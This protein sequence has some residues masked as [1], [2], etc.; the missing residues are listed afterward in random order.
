LNFS[1][2]LGAEAPTEESAELD[3]QLLT[4]SIEAL[5]HMMKTNRSAVVF[6]PV[7]YRTISSGATAARYVRLLE[8]MP[9]LYRMFLMLEICGLP[10]GLQPDRIHATAMVLQRFAKYIAVELAIDDARLRAVS[11]LGA[12]GISLDLVG[13]SILGPRFMPQLKHFAAAATAAEV[14]AVARGAN[15]M[16]MALAAWEA[17][18][19]YIEGTSIHL[20]VK[21]PRQPL[22]L[23]P[24]PSPR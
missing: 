13:M 18:F 17:G 12:W 5:Y 4:K 23:R 15:S 21:E 16:G 19:T 1:D 3:C 9:P 8:S 14:S 11:D 10:I 22:L 24:L 20:P 2:F 6:V 7:D